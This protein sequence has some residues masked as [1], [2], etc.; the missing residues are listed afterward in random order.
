MGAL[1]EA[2]EKECSVIEKTEPMLRKESPE[3]MG[4][5]TLPYTRATTSGTVFHKVPD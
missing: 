4:R 1:P 2:P 5:I 3:S